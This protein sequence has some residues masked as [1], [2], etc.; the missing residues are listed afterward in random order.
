MDLAAN[1]IKTIVEQRIRLAGD[2]CRQEIE[3]FLDPATQ[4]AKHILSYGLDIA[5]HVSLIP[6]KCHCRQICQK[7]VE[8]EVW[9]IRV[10]TAIDSS[11]ATTIL[12]I[13]LQQAILSQ[14]HFS[15]FNAWLLD[16]HKGRLPRGHRC[17]YRLVYLFVDRFKR[18]M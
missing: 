14:L 1:L 16:K 2:N 15:P 8:F 17:V 6:K 5:V 10:K 7:A 11:D 18:F 9:K 3:T 13:F 4:Q 12:P